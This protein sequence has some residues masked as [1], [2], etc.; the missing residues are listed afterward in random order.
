MAISIIRSL[1][2]LDKNEA[3]RLPLELLV[4][5]HLCEIVAHEILDAASLEPTN[6]LAETEKVLFNLGAGYRNLK[7]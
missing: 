7:G 5:T 1:G 2:I 4:T 3:R 6:D